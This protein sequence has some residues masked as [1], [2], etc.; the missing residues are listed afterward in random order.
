RIAIVANGSGPAMV[1]ADQVHFQGL[2]MAR[3]SEDTATSLRERLPHPG[4]ANPLVLGIDA[5]P[6]D[7]EQAIAIVAADPSVD[8]I[9]VMH[10]PAVGVDSAG[11]AAAVGAAGAKAR[12]PV[13]T[14]WLGGAAVM[15]HRDT[16]VD[17]GLPSFST[18]ASA[19][20]AF[21]TVAAFYQNQLLLQEVPRSLS[22]LEAP[23]LAGARAL[24]ASAVAQGREVLTE[25]ESK[26]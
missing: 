23:D 5:T 24:V 16:L 3:F 8:G 7:H 26:A 19:V 21:A 17:A 14:C 22:S 2:G 6:A 20:D 4:P 9:L 10:S 13:F 25:I 15:P 18:P 1:A 11:V 12:K